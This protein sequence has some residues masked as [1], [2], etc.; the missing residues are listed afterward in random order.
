MELPVPG[1]I[2]ALIGLLLGWVD[3]KVVAGVV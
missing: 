1:L 2:G 3:Y